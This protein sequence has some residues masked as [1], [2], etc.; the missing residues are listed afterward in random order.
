M[1][2]RGR[3]TPPAP[4]RRDGHRRGRRPGRR[5]RRGRP[6]RPDASPGPRRAAADADADARPSTPEVDAAPQ[7]ALGREFRGA[8]FWWAP[9]ASR[10]AELPVLQVPGLPD[11]LSMADEAPYV[12]RRRRTTSTRSSAPASS[13]TPAA[14]TAT[15]CRSTCPTASGRWPTRRATRSAPGSAQRLAGRHPGRSFRQPGRVEVW[16]LPEQLVAHRGDAGLRERAVVPRRAALDRRRA[17]ARA[18]RPMDRARHPVLA[19]SWSGRAARRELDFTGGSAVVPRRRRA[20][21]LREPRAPGGAPGRHRRACWGSA[22]TGAARG[23]APSW[24]GSATTSCSSRP[25]RWIGGRV[26]AWRVGTPDLYRVSEFTDFPRRARVVQL[27]RERVHRLRVVS[28]S[29]N[30]R[31]R[32]SRAWSRSRRVATTAARYVSAG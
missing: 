27:G 16:D 15:S 12:G 21:S 31:S 25:R 11:E 29:R 5:R 14:T 30:A 22:S 17:G 2:A 19:R 6:G 8:P 24:G 7:A 4:V 10:D 13:S 18:G 1:G 32:P 26:L 3:R 23:A 9:P 28:R 20:R